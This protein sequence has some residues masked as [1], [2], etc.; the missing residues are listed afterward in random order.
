MFLQFGTSRFLQAHADLILS[1]ANLSRQICV[2]QSSGSSETSDRITHL[3]KDDGFPVRIQ[4]RFDG[5]T[6]DREIR[7][8]SIR[9]ALSSALQWDDVIAEALECRFILSN[10]SEAGYRPQ[11][12]DHDTHFDN[13]MSYIAKLLLV[14]KARFT[15]GRPPVTIMPLE[16]FPSNGSYLKDRVLTLAK[17][18]G[19]TADFINWLAGNIWVNSLV[20]RI[21]SEPL[22]PIGAVTEPY[23]LWA[24][25]KSAKLNLPFTHP[26]VRLV[27]DLGT[28]ERLKL[29]ILNLSHT[30]MA[31]VWGAQN[32]SKTTT[33]RD[34]ICD[35]AQVP[36]YRNMIENEV[37]PAFATA[38]MG[39]QAAD[40]FI[41]TYERF[42]NPFLKHQIADIANGHQAKVQSRICG[43]LDWANEIGD[44]TPK[45]ILTAIAKGNRP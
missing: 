23:C 1:E 34:F 21:V 5:K 22:N 19:E 30:Y 2:V 24:I 38:K 6:I 20:D 8:T 28:Y 25:E 44:A 29:Y 10:V 27:D 35:K 17:E 12:R 14:L 4:G 36:T 7:V 41:N 18:R 31:E 3:A 33:V 39:D 37:L 16:L 32:M 26:A 43:F 9:R 13:A 15:A 11:A 42:E 45:P 40:Y